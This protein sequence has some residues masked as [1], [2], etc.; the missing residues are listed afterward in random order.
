FVA[1]TQAGSGQPLYTARAAGGTVRFEPSSLTLTLPNAATK[2]E[3]ESSPPSRHSLTME[4]INSAGAQVTA[5]ELLPGT[6]SY[7]LGDDPSAW[8]ANL[9]TYSSITYRGLYQGVDLRYEG[10]D[11]ALKGTYTLAPGTDAAGIRWRYVG[12]GTPAVDEYGNLK[13]SLQSATDSGSARSAIQ[14]SA[15]VAWQEVAGRRVPVEARYTVASDGSAGFTLGHYD[16]SLTL[17]IDPTLTYSTYLGTAEDD[18]AEDMALDSAGNIYVLGSTNTYDDFW[19]F[20]VTKL[21]P[22]GQQVLYQVILGGTRQDF[23]AALAVDGAGNAHVLGNVTSNNFPTLN[24][25]QAQNL[26]SVE[27]TISKLSPTGAMLWSTYLGTPGAEAGS[28]IALDS[29]GNVYLS[30]STAEPDFPMVNAYQPAN[31]GMIDGF[32][33]GINAAGTAILF[34]TYFGG[35]YDDDMRDVWVDASNNIYV[36]GFTRST[37]LPVQNAYQPQPSGDG[38]AFVTKFTPQAQGLV[39][40]TYLGGNNGTLPGQDIGEAIRT[41]SIGNVYVTGYTESPSFPTTPGSVQPNTH[42]G[43]DAF[44]TK[45]TPDGQ[46]LVWSTYLGGSGTDPRGRDRATAITIDAGGYVYITGSTYSLD[47]PTANAVQPT[48]AGNFDA[49]VSKFTPDGSSLAYSTYLGGTYNIGVP[50]QTGDDIGVAI[51]IDP[52]GNALIAGTSGSYNFPTVN[53]Y[54]QDIQG[55]TDYFLSRI[56]EVNPTPTPTVT[57]TPPTATP[58]PPTAT[59]FPSFTPTPT[60]TPVCGQDSY[61]YI[62]AITESDPIAANSLYLDEVASTCAAPKTCPDVVGDKPGFDQYRFTNTSGAPRCI[63]VAL[64]GTDCGSVESVVSA[65]YLGAFD[66]SNSCANYLADGGTDSMWFTGPI[67]YSF[68]VPAGAAFG[69]VVQELNSE[70]GCSRYILNVSGLGS[71]CP[72]ATVTPTSPPTTGTA[73]AATNTPVTTG[74]AQATATRTSVAT[75]TVPGTATAVVSAT[76]CAMSFSDVPSGSSFYGYVTCLACER[77]I[78]GYSDG[79]FR[80][81]NAVTR[82]QLSKIVALS[83]AMTDPVE[84]QSF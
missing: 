20:L 79:T 33:T 60:V 12:A 48:L 80:P 57:G 59:Q 23:G 32:V 84:G 46:A 63:T 24:P 66:P 54:Q 37:N 39:W 17:V 11:G 22:H 58:R 47:F 61:T 41:D 21:S 67:S 40:S 26:G 69:V 65:A 15:P 51:E 71:T 35:Q 5:G 36:T 45:F 43:L 27:L 70:A 4:F 72:Q 28:Q 49:F 29:V 19:D 25:I 44:V 8:Q 55:N 10:T 68:T 38:D 73:Q 14:E 7:Y 16:R 77:V 52:R 56:E 81:G 31:A 74:T 9:P 75:G 62:G 3:S 83:A 6:V 34:S 64:D 82:G 42:G 30:G 2:G 13:I 50:G 1:N 18:D 78:S 53:A 76:A